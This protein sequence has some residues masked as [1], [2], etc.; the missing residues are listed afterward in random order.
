MKMNNLV[1]FYQD[2][3]YVYAYESMIHAIVRFRNGNAEIIVQ[4]PQSLHKTSFQKLLVKH[5]M[6]YMYTRKDARIFLY[7]ME[8]KTMGICEPEVNKDEDMVFLS[9]VIIHETSVILLPR[10][11]GSIF[12]FDM[13]GRPM[14]HE[15]MKAFQTYIQTKSRQK[16]AYG[17][18][19][20]GAYIVDK[21]L[22]CILSQNKQDVIAVYDMEHGSVQTF[23]L[24]TY[25]VLYSLSYQNQT[26]FVQGIKSNTLYIIGFTVDG[27]IIS[28]FE[29]STAPRLHMQWWEN[30]QLYVF[31]EECIYIIEQPWD[32]TTEVITHQLPKTFHYLETQYL[33]DDNG[34]VYQ[35]VNRDI[36]KVPDYQAWLYDNATYI[37]LLK[38]TIT[39]QGCLVFEQTNFNQES[40]CNMLGVV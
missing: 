24:G 11:D 40:F 33:Y 21:K 35:F 20:W 36:H 38:Q 12:Q 15:A 39:Q 16:E 7:D 23:A 4:I 25:E 28:E 37:E 18:R 22:V 2:N 5:N 3:G 1:C 19:A 30:Q 32:Q 31:E 26:F 8:Q 13:L 10:F 27:T 29:L 9:N 34:V 6:I 14:E 17:I